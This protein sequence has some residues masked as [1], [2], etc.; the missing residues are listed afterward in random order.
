VATWADVRR[1]CARLPETE[2]VER[3]GGT[4]AWRVGGK[5]YAWERPLGARDVAALGDATPTGPVLAVRVADEGA[6]HALVADASGVYFTTP[7]F[8]GYPAVLVR[9]EALDPAELVEL[10]TE[11]WLARAPKRLTRAWNPNQDG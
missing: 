7:H 2:P 9:L 10:L 4:A 5:L 11:A 3:G 1:A 6:K 8:N